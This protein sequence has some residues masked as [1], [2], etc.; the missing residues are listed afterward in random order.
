MNFKVN[1]DALG[2]ATSVAC[3]IHCAVLPLVATSLPLFG[4]NILNNEMFEYLMIL[5]ALVVGI[6]S[7]WHGFRKHHHSLFPILLF[8][9]GFILL[10]SKQIWHEVSYFLLIPAVILIVTAH[11]VNYR[12][13]RVHNH[14]H[15]DD[16]NH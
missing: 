15:H 14:A 8:I 6:W 4:I 7:L 3:A 10:I 9:A 13:C 12:K 1:W 2:I 16:C 5:L 11:W